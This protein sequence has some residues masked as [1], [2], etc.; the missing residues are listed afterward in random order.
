MITKAGYNT[1]VPG[2]KSNP[3]L[4]MFR[5]VARLMS[6]W[7]NNS[8]YDQNS[9]NNADQTPSSED[10]GPASPS[11]SS[12]SQTSDTSGGTYTG[13]SNASGSASDASSNVSG[14]AQGGYSWQSGTANGYGGNTNSNTDGN[15]TNSY[16]EGGSG[17][18]SQS[19][20]DPYGW[21]SSNGYSP[22]PQGGQPGG[23]KPPKRNKG[24]MAGIIA[25]VG[26][27]CAAAIVTLSVLLAME[28]NDNGPAVSDGGSSGG[29]TTSTT[30]KVNE[31]APSLVIDADES[32]EA[33]TTPE[34]VQKNLDSTVVISM[35]SQSSNSLYG[36]G[37]SESQLTQVGAASGIVMTA[38]GYII[39]NWHCVINEDTGIAY[40]RVDVTTYD[41]TVYENATIVGA[42]EYT[43][44]AVI[45][46]GAANLTPAEFGDS[47]ALQLGET[48]V[49]IGNAGG[50]KY[51]VSKGIVS[52]L[53]RDVYENS[54]YAIK[55]VQVD[56]AINS[57]NSGGPLLNNRGQVVGVNSAKMRTELGYENMG[58]AIP[59]SDAQTI[60]NDLVK[61][62]YVKG[63]VM[64]GITGENITQTGYEGF[65][66]RSIDSDSVLNGT[67]AQV[68]DIIT[69]IDGVRVK[70]QTEL[71]SELA[72]HEVGDQITLTLLR[73]DSRTR[74]TVEL[75][76][77]VTL[78]ESRG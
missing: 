38:D 65:M 70:S 2:G 40:D 9:W 68:G 76:V 60:I 55:C 47:T 42:D 27:L 57:G 36:F 18:Q 58:F 62:G 73:I 32:E 52:G 49:A 67:N 25:G 22:A 17:Y 11:S 41:G 10:S 1:L 6:D 46:V 48:V 61:Y 31:N 75:D 69:E 16:Q 8:R 56:A 7:N 78:A 13:W 21:H 77:T 34:I 28:V 50:L 59:I 51:S 74:Q 14:S 72:K 39:T 29:T 45:K 63:R 30:G 43:D 23:Q 3:P 15:N 19:S 26:V 66:I 35:Y 5:K 53:D 4:K 37:N 24:L 12:S 54:D 33:L 20:Y 71:R 64:L 44:L